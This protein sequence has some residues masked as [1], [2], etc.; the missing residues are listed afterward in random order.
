[1]MIMS[2]VSAA[3]S[4]KVLIAYFS[5]AGEN[6]NV[7]YV[8]AGNTAVMT[9]YIHERL[10]GSDIFTIEPVVPYPDTYDECTDVAKKEQRE[11]ARPAVKTQIS[12]IDKYDVIFIGYPIWW[13]TIPQIL[14]TFL[15]AYNL[16]GKTIIPFCTHEGSGFGRSATDLRK[17]SPRSK[18]IEGLAVRGSEAR[19]AQ[20][21]VNAWIDRTMK[22]VK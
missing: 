1:M 9:G 22:A 15:E 7:G 19:N 3:D 18:F 12:D 14:F 11:N 8:K 2:N 21:E 5:R 6:Y 20:K 13:G 16:S 4:A 10:S 17:T